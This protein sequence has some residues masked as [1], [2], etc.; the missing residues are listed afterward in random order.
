MHASVVKRPPA[1]SPKGTLSHAS[2]GWRGAWPGATRAVRLGGELAARHGDRAGDQTQRRRRIAEARGAPVSVTPRSG[3]G[4]R[5][6]AHGGVDDSGGGTPRKAKGRGG[7]QSRAR[8]R[9]PSG[10]FNH[11]WKGRSARSPHSTTPHSPRAPVLSILLLLELVIGGKAR[12]ER[13]SGRKALL[14]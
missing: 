4:R 10:G 11:G 7:G 8:P 12:E 13:H 1:P 5:T 3:T 14:G 2:N 9:A 6:A